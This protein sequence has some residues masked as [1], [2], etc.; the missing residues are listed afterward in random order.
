MNGLKKAALFLSSLEYAE[1]DKLLSRLDGE[2]AKLVRREMMSLKHHDISA[3]ATHHLD[4][5]FLHSAGLP[6]SHRQNSHRQSPKENPHRQTYREYQ[7][8]ETPAFP[9]SRASSALPKE[10]FIP[11]VRSF[12]FMQ[13]WSVG[14]IV[15]AVIDEHPQTIAVVL[16]HLPQSKMHSVLSALPQELQRDVQC[17]LDNFAT[18]SPGPSEQIIR[19]IESALKVR[20]RRQHRPAQHSA[21]L[22]YFDD[23][24]TLSDPQ[25]ATLFRSVDLITAMLA[26]IG[27]D[28]TLIARVTKHF[29]PTEE[30]EMRKQF[31]R[32]GSVGEDE[33]EQAR[34][35][36][37]EQYNGT[38]Y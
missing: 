15:N 5:E 10:S 19:E 1:A 25:L 18:S 3:E 24:G 28:A 31:S 9:E 13:H 7:F 34:T 23:I 29:T 12:D 27:A 36:I 20:Y 26:L 37:L 17:R 4:K 32:L 6:I 33:V 35:Y 38:R 14:D 30:H 8:R 21:A 16:A 22:E 11:P 2:S